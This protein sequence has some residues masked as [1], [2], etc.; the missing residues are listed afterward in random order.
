MRVTPP[1]FLTVIVYTIVSP[2][3]VVPFPLSVTVAVLV[4][5]S[6]GEE[7]IV[8]TVSSSVVFPSPSIPLSLTSVTSLLLP[9]PVSYTHLTLPTKRIV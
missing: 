5:S 9:G 6:D 8:V 7:V 1:S 3:P 2:F 4:T